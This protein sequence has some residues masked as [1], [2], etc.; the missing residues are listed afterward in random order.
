VRVV[1]ATDG[2]FSTF[3]AAGAYT[4][5]ANLTE[6]LDTY[7]ALQRLDVTA[8]MTVSIGLLRATNVTGTT[9]FGGNPVASVPVTFTRTEGAAVTGT[10][11][12]FGQYHVLVLGGTY[13][14]S[15]DFAGTTAK[16][17]GVAYVRYTFSGS[18]TVTQNTQIAVYN[19]DLAQ[20]LDNTTI[21]G[22]VRFNGAPVIAQLTFLAR[23]D[24]GINTTASTG[25]DGRYRF[26]LQPGEYR[27]YAVAGLD[28][29]VALT[30]YVH[31]PGAT[32]TLD[33][34]LVPG[35]RVSGV[36]TRDG[37]RTRANVTFSTAAGEARLLS[38]AS[39]A[40]S[41]LLPETSYAVEASTGGTER[42][43]SV[44]Y[45]ATASLV[46]SE[47]TVLNLD[48]T[49]AVRRQVDLTWDAAQKATIP[50]GGVV[51]YEFTVTNLGNADDTFQLAAT[52]VGF[53]FS[54]SDN[55]V[56]VPFG[57]TGNTRTVQVTITA[58]GD[59]K[60]E[61][62]PI[63]ITA[64]STSDPS[65]TK[66]VAVEVDVVRYRGMRAGV[67]G[68]A[69]TWDGRFLNYTLEVRN[70][71][72]G[73]ETFRLTLPNE[74]ELA[75]VGWRA[76]L[77]GPAGTPQGVLNLTVPANATQR[78]VLRLQKFGGPAGATA[79]VQVTSIE[80]GLFA[81]LVRVRLQM[82]ALAV[83]GRIRAVGSGVAGLEPGIDL[84]TAALLVS[85]VAVVGAAAYL[86]ILRRRSR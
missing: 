54:F 51:T 64:S 85:F 74:D 76:T 57:T 4:V 47:P 62:P 83:D 15:V 1:N 80:D 13:A 86:S 70:L 59:A 5:T 20:A 44:T 50:P 28:G 55:R 27:V 45:R 6:G 34:S 79:H 48:L 67:S 71:G 37:V 84:A 22:T 18:L 72:N 65:A 78:P 30:T 58:N 63:S 3:L 42:G 52:G 68:E 16:G 53:T 9:Q 60:V 73:Q 23:G 33:L 24:T 11:D 39:G 12:P 69:P 46:L 7:L 26:S 66:S 29:A 21:E 10:S 36:T 25:S 31:A 77:V 14:V 38:D 17:S 49:K 35:I 8:P 32:R 19:V 40:Y 82:P 43:L 61:H 75:A 56:E 81:S 41:I 2:S